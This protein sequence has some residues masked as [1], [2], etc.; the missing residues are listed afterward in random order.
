M[1]K[2]KKCVVWQKLEA[3]DDKKHWGVYPF[4]LHTLVHKVPIGEV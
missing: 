1:Q 3:N 2:D 4:S